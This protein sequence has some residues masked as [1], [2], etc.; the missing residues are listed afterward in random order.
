MN[1][2][3]LM[4]IIQAI[5]SVVL[6]GVILSIPTYIIAKREIENIK[7]SLFEDIEY[8]FNSE[9]GQKLIFSIGALIGNGAKSGI[10]LNLPKQKG[11]LEGFLM[12][13]ASQFIQNK[14]VKSELVQ[15]EVKQGF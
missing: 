3:I 15:N 7:N 4:D 9:K 5:L 10:G 11:G 1:R 14:L 2:C 8:Y 12:N 13:I 6:S